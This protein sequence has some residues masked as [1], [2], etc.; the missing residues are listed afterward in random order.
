MNANARDKIVLQ[1][2]ISTII[3]AIVNVE[4]LAAYLTISS[5][6]INANVNV[7]IKLVLMDTHLI[8]KSVTVSVFPSN[9][10]KTLCLTLIHAHVNAN[11]NSVQ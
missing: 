9:V 11:K 2:I 3:Y 6:K 7:S 1:D 4:K 5:I 10:L 8:V